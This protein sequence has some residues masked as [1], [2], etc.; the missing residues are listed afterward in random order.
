MLEQ[1][2]DLFTSNDFFYTCDIID[3]KYESIYQY[4][5]KKL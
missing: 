3:I 4:T 1:K 2:S 5:F